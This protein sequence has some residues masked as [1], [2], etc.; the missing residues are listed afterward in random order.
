MSQTCLQKTKDAHKLMWGVVC[1]LC[2]SFFTLITCGVCRFTR[3]IKLRL[4]YHTLA[5]SSRWFSR[6]FDLALTRNSMYQ[7]TL[8]A[9]YTL[10]FEVCA[11]VHACMFARVRT[12]VQVWAWYFYHA[13]APLFQ[14][15]DM[16]LCQDAHRG[17]LR[18]IIW[19]SSHF[20]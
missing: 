19:T 8:H 7:I 17:S 12:H 18:M 10:S 14:R 20:S 11:C 4:E 16:F 13:F 9:M 15:I 5:P 3:I 6:N 2:V 1:N